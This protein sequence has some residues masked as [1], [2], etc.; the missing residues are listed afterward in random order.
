MR[1]EKRA[2]VEQSDEPKLH[3]GP[4]ATAFS[5]AAPRSIV[6]PI[7]IDGQGAEAA[8]TYGK[9]GMSV[10]G[11]RGGRRLRMPRCSK[12]MAKP[13]VLRRGRQTRVRLKDFSAAAAEA[14]A[15]DGVIK[16]PMHGKV[17]ELFVGAGDAVRG[18]QRLAVI[19]A[20]K[21]EH[22]LARAVRR[23]R[24]RRCGRRPARK[25]WK[26]RGSW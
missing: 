4:R 23:H 21:M 5:S 16:A 10:V 13:I 24:R 8:V 9:D 22:T 3:H 7:L 2:S 14:G 25:L 11:R 26:A 20:M 12:R 15:G 19:E 1:D 18:G 17:L 6:V